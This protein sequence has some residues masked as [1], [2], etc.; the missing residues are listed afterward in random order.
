VKIILSHSGGTLPFLA[1][2]ISLADA[3]PSLQCPRNHLQILEDFRSFYFDTALT[4]SIPQL[5]VL[6]EFVDTSKILFDS[7]IPYAPLP[8]ILQITKNLDKF[9]VKNKSDENLW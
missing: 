5:Q 4:S 6:L 7:D 1:H 3:V 2:R 8:A 9:F